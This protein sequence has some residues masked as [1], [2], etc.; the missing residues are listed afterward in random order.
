MLIDYPQGIRGLRL[1]KSHS[2][3]LLHQLY[4]LSPWSWEKKDKE[5]SRGILNTMHV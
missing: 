3:L 4:Q 2:T 1:W 5:N